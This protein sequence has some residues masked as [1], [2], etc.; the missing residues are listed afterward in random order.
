LAAKKKAAGSAPHQD[1]ALAEWFVRRPGE[2]RYWLVKSEPEVF[3]FDDLMNAPKQTTCWDGVRNFAARNFLKDGMRKGDQVFYYHS[4]ANPQAIVGI[5]EVVKE[6]YPDSTALDPKHHHFDEQS[7]PANP[8]WYM[9]DVKAVARLKRPVT[10]AAIKGTKS[11]AAMALI[12][13]GRLSVI[14]ISTSEWKT[15]LKMAE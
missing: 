8:T 6:G 12:R 11:L 3:S 13:T 10:L 7:D 14:P 9:V 4:M 15:I 1:G 5:C 2:V